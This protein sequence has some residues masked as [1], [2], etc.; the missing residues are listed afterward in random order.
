MISH[1]TINLMDGSV[2]QIIRIACLRWNRGVYAG[3]V[4]SIRCEGAS[5]GSGTQEMLSPKNL[6]VGM[7]PG[8]EVALIDDGRFSGGTRGAGMGYVLPEAAAGGP[9]AATME[10]S[11]SCPD[12]PAHLPTGAI[13]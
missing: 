8:E 10:T 11:F 13:Q 12:P 6:I 1:I 3:D 7:E 2:S 9:I 5:G 4:V